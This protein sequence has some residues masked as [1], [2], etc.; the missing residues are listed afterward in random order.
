VGV[1]HH[2]Q[3]RLSAAQIAEELAFVLTDDW[4]RRESAYRPTE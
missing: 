2:R 1:G 4:Q 3:G